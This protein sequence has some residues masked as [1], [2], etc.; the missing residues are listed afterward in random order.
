MYIKLATDNG[1]KFTFFTSKDKGGKV[2][3]NTDKTVFGT[4]SEGIKVGEVKG[5]TQYEND[6]WNARFCGK[7]YE[8]ALTLTDQTR[9]VVTEM[10]IRN[11]RDAQTKR[12]YP[13]IM[14]TD[15]F[16]PEAPMQNENVSRKQADEEGFMPIPDGLGEELYD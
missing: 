10:T 6:Y 8:K 7:A 12:T 13:Q 15:F 5:I 11:K 4:L 9:V 2:K 16:V 1:R 3:E 14:V